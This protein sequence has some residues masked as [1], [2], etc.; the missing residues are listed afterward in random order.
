[1][2]YKIEIKKAAGN[3]KGYTVMIDFF[4]KEG[5]K[6]LATYCTHCNTKKE[7]KEWE[8]KNKDWLKNTAKNL[9]KE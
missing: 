6:Y 2:K 8:I 1:M 3:Q 5:E 7:A 9:E 4:H